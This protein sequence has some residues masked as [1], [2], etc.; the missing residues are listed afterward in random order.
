MY[1]RTHNEMTNI[2]NRTF[3]YKY[4][5][6]CGNQSHER[7]EV[8]A[9]IIDKLGKSWLI[10]KHCSEGSKE[11]VQCVKPRLFMDWVNMHSHELTI[12]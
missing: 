9:S 1:N 10:V 3:T 7:K 4:Q 5:D 12:D 2:L 8:V 6:N 11:S